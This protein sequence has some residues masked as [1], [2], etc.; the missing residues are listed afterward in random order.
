MKKLALTLLAMGGLNPPLQAEQTE[1]LDASAIRED[2]RILSSDGFQG[3]GPGERGESMTLAY[4]KAQFE[5]AGLSPGGPNGSWFQEVPLTRF[6][7][8]DRSFE[9][10]IGSDRLPLE[11]ARDWS[12]ADA[13]LG[14]TQFSDS[15]LV[16]VGFGIHAPEVQWDDYAGVDL[17]GKIAVMLYNDPDWDQDSGPFGGHALSAYGRRARKVLFAYER[18]ATGVLLVYQP[19]IVSASWRQP[20]NSDPDPAWQLRSSATPTGGAGLQMVLR[21]EPAAELFRRTGHDLANL[22]RQAQQRGFRA[23]PLGAATL[24]AGVTVRATP[25]VTRNIIARLDG[26]ERASETVIFGA[27]WDAYGK[28]PPDER[29]DTIRNGAIDNGIGTATLLE[30][31]R[32]FARSPRTKRTLLFMGFTAEEDGLLGAYHY[33]SHPVRPLGTTAAMFN[34]DPHLALP[35]TRTMEL[36]GAGRTDLEDDL[37][38]VAATQGLQMEKEV[39][40]EAGWYRRS[41]HL[42]FAEAG[43]PVVYFRAGRDLEIGGASI[44]SALVS[45]YNSERYHQRTDEFDP[46]WDMVAASQEGSLVYALG[47]GIADSDQWPSW[48]ENADYRAARD[49]SARERR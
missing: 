43:V 29:G 11:Q 33:A 12:I 23:V 16:F 25:V 31:A 26:T 9:L 34:I 44:G 38:R 32:V 2:V 24:S 28:G 35:R 19:A 40:P 10:R 14:R 22:S 47:R 41:D 37:S 42:A 36:I 15:P 17:N 4:L 27:H 18:G 7:K 8:S 1:P 39:S 49:K 5:A 3:R 6:D 48:R 13:P 20:A 45:A 21:E 46:A 30:L